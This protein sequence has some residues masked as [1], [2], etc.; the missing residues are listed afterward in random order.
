[1]RVGICILC[2]VLVL[3][4]PGVALTADEDSGTA[5]SSNLTVQQTFEGALATYVLQRD[6]AQSERAFLRVTQRDPKF[7]PAWFNLGILAEQDK[8]WSDAKDCFQR[9]LEVA[10]NGPDAARA[11]AELQLLGEYVA[12]TVTPATQRREEYHSAID[13]ARAYLATGAYRESIAEAGRAQA[14]DPANWESYAVVSLCLAKQ[15]NLDAAVKFETEAWK[16]APPGEEE[17]IRAILAR[18][19]ADWNR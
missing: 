16:H 4:R 14:M 17:K 7:A 6:R 1:M 8:R 3:S 13:R 18:Q 11:T 9:Y 5:G 2:S 12:G 10:P 19:I 15:H